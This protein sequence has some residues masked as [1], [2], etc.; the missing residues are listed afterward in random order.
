M[1]MGNWKLKLLAGACAIAAG[2]TASGAEISTS[3][4]DLS[5]RFDNTL[6][7]GVAKRLK[8]QDSA[9]LEDVNLDDGDRN[10][11]KNGLISNRLDILSELDLTYRDVGLRVS[12]AAWYD[13]A[14][15]RG[16]ENNSPFTSNN[17]SAPYNQFARG[18][19]DLHGRKAEVLDAFVF[20]KTYIDDLLVTGR[21][22]KH[23]VVFG[24]SLFFGSNGIAAAQAPIDFVKLLSVPGTQF[25]ELMRPVPQLSGQLQVNENVSIGGYYQF[26]W[27]KDRIPGA[28][29]YFSSADILDAGGERILLGPSF[30]LNRGADVT[31]KNS[32]QGGLQVKFRTDGGDTDYGLYAV[33]YHAKSPMTMPDF[34]TATYSLFYPEKIKSIGASLSTTLLDTNFGAEVSIRHNMPLVPQ[35][36][37]I[38]GPTA[39]PVGKTLHAQVSWVKLMSP[40]ALWGG[41]QFLGEI[42]YH[43]VTSVDGNEAALDPNGTRAASAFRL[44]FAPAYYQALSGVDISIPIGL[45]YGI[46]GRSLIINPGFSPKKTGDFSIGIKGEYAK[47]WQM[48][49]TYTKF[50][51]AASTVLTPANSPVAAYSYG[52]SLADREFLALSVQRTF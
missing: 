10:F 27:E 31:P 42:A 17:V 30:A 13:R 25:K 16:N 9:L 36:G 24:E 12:A 7:Y 40:S 18:T 2:T 38:A 37:Q 4:N 21:L 39:Y 48:S 19:K 1:E 14:Y 35:A 32:G 26:R 47:V 22:G 15:M 5:I 41:G 44:L 46:S 29:S 20:G 3:V 43:R 34:T 8:S 52:Q 45:G 49:L 51:G 11:G 28:G 33:Q 6:K 23:T 50:L